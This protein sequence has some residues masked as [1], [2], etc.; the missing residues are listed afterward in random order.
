[1][2][3]ITLLFLALLFCLTAC[4][5]GCKKNSGTSE[6][7][8]SSSESEGE[9]IVS[10]STL[11]FDKSKGYTAD[12]PLRFEI[13]N[14]KYGPELPYARHN[15]VDDSSWHARS[16]KYDAPVYSYT[17]RNEGSNDLMLIVFS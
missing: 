5:T 8:E 7:S 14:F 1:M 11:D 2:K 16:F 12:M 6:N 17:P 4:F 15:A 13:A 3:R 10:T 9:N